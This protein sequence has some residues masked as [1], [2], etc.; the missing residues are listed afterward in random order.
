MMRGGRGGQ[1]DELTSTPQS[2]CFHFVSASALAELCWKACTSLCTDGDS[3]TGKGWSRE[4]DVPMAPP[5]KEELSL[6][7]ADQRSRRVSA[8]DDE[9]GWP[10]IHSPTIIANIM[11]V[12]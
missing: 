9:L 3:C 7:N 5:N 6:T 8:L 1:F 2:S 10:E 12:Q 4:K 11:V